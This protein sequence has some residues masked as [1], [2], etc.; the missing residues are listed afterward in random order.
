VVG[1]VKVPSPLPDTM[2]IA[3]DPIRV[4]EYAS[5]ATMSVLPS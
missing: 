4:S 5:R 3:L 2:L 1:A